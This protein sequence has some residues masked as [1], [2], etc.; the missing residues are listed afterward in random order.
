MLVD[1][2][3]AGYW[4][5]EDQLRYDEDLAPLQG[6]PQFERAV[7]VSTSRFQAAGAR[8]KPDIVLLQPEGLQ[9]PY[10]LL[11]ALHGRGGN[12][13]D[14]A[15]IWKPALE[16]GL[17]LALPQS[18]QLFGIDA[19]A[20]DDGD[21]AQQQI[22]FQ[23]AELCRQGTVDRTRVIVTGFSQ[24]G[25]LAIWLAMSGMVQARGFIAVAP[26][27]RF[28]EHIAPLIPTGQMLGLRGY[29]I[30]GER[31]PGYQQTRNLVNLLRSNG[32]PCEIESHP[33]LGHDYPPG[34]QRSLARGLEFVMSG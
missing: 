17:M 14:D 13:R 4:W 26:S 30:T 1:A 22:T 12:A 27:L 5:S 16:H 11:I 18:A 32:I 20:W 3:D 10:P 29:V 19:Y 25:S 34:F 8:S 33:E 24:G 9:P 31:D 23:F 7:E 28:T 21:R 6:L 2:I 15:E